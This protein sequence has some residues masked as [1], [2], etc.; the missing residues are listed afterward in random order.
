LWVVGIVIGIVAVEIDHTHAAS[1]EPVGDDRPVARLRISLEAQKAGGR[2]LSDLSQRGQ[3]CRRPVAGEMLRGYA[4]KL[5]VTT[6]PGRVATGLWIAQINKV[7][8][9]YSRC[10]KSSSKRGF[11]KSGLTRQ[12][13]S[14][15]VREHFH[16]NNLQRSGE[17]LDIGPLVA[18]RVN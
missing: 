18:E 4:P 13:H 9:G 12:R 14:A 11:G 1:T 17:A 15:N 8:I 5:V 16:A 3:G 6:R 2:L 7:R 10:A